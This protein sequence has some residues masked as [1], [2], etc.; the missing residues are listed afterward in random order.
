MTTVATMPQ[1]NP[2][3][4][5][6]NR[7]LGEASRLYRQAGLS[8]PPVPRELAGRLREY[9][10]WEYGTEFA[11]LTDQNG[12]LIAARDPETPTQVGFGHVG[13][14]ITSWWL[15]YRLI[16]ESCAVYFR[17][18]Y[19]GAYDDH[20]AAQSFINPIVEQI[21]VLISRADAAHSSGRIAPDRRLVVVIDSLGGSGWQIAG[22]AHG[23]RD[24][25]KPIDEAMAFLDRA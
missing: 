16:G 5:T 2:T 1:R 10:E 4:P 17:Q 21:A 6:S 23:W 7:A 22:D 11:D 25:D 18:S 20:E 15:C 12:F 19:G 14:G 8:L 24:S 13:H 9:A 3:A